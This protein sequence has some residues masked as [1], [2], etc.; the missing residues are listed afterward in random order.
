MP[1]N[2][3]SIP[4]AR[5]PS[6]LEVA[7][8]ER[9]WNWLLELGRQLKVDLLLL[10]ARASVLVPFASNEA[11]AGLH[12]L[13]EQRER[14]VLSA[15]GMGLRGG[16]TQ[17]VEAE[18]LQIV[19]LVLSEE[20]TP[21]GALVLGRGVS[22]GLEPLSTRVHLELVGGWLRAAVELHLQSPP[23]QHASGL[24][25]IHPLAMLL[26]QSAEHGSDRE[27]IRVFGEAVAV[28]HDIEVC[29][30]VEASG[31]AFIADVVPPG[32]STGERPVSLSAADL[33]DSNELIQLPQGHLD[34]FRLPVDTDVYVRRFRRSG[35]RSWLL[36]FTG[37]IDAYDLQRLTAY[38]ALLELALA[39]S[40]TA[41]LAKLMPT[42]GA[43]LADTERLPADRAGQALEELRTALDASWAALA[44]ERSDGLPPLSVSSPPGAGTG[45]QSG[46]VRLGLVKRSEQH[47]T[48][49][50]SLGRGV[51]LPFTPR[52]HD[53]AGAALELFAAWA[54]TGPVATRGERERRA[55]P[56]T[57]LEVL[58]RAAREAGVRGAPV[59]ILVLL[60]RG[61]ATPPGSTQQWVAGMRGQMRALDLVGVLAER[62]IGVLLHNTS[63]ERA[64][65]VGTRARSIVE[66]QASGATVSW[67]MASR[68]PGAGTTDGLVDEARALAFSGRAGRR[69]P[70]TSQEARS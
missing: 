32:Q 4:V 15:I 42:L 69:A 51:D 28:W 52:D 48:T 29:G 19:S 39:L 47:Y 44:V 12:A 16:T 26:E 33:P 58:E 53:V 66:A 60:A 50:V 11:P 59:T 13:V 2:E 40:T 23:A 10:D 35:L 1:N 41:L 17:V 31:G 46:A 57:F 14:A 54:A 61:A 55:A 65:T 63:A 67:G 49:T 30:Y 68:T 56:G 70:G 7:V 43:L 64:T 5:E 38:V 36:V 22:T 37:A 8:R 3:Q 45:A 6:G 27:L 18:G 24:D 9:S 25:H 62:E 34:R 21:V 20:H